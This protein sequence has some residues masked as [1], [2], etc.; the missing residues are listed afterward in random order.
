LCC[1]RVVQEGLTN[2]ARHAPGAAVRVRLS[3]G[4]DLD[5]TITNAI[6]TRGGLLGHPDRDG[7]GLIGMRERVTAVGGD[8][9]AGNVEADN[10]A[11][12]FRVRARLPIAASGSDR[13]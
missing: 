12:G 4:S 2:A 10:G 7:F 13:G 3:Y 8:F 5:V 9:V 6:T 11:A 1:Y